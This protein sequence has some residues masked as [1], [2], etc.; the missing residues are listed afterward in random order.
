MATPS[1]TGNAVAPLPAVARAGLQ[2]AGND[3]R[4]AHNSLPAQGLTAIFGW[5]ERAQAA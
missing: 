2:R 4:V 5:E 3:A 1:R